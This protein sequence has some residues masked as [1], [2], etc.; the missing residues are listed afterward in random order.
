MS[1]S[2]EA[3]YLLLGKRLEAFMKHM[4]WITCQTKY[5]RME[6]TGKVGQCHG[7]RS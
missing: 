3:L 6:R 4:T 1:C 2:A 7:S 5:S